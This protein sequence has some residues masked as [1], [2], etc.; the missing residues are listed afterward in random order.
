LTPTRRTARLRPQNRLDAPRRETSGPAR[1]FARARRGFTAALI[2]VGL[3]E[4]RADAAASADAPTLFPPVIVTTNGTGQD[5]FLMP[6][7]TAVLMEDALRDR[8]ARTLP[9]AFHEVPGIMVQKTGTAQGSPYLRGFTGFRTLLLVDG[10]RLNNSVFREGPNQYWGTVDPL[11]LERLEVVKGPGSVIHG[12]DAVGGTVNAITTPADISAAA[13]TWH[14]RALHRFATADESHVGRLEVAGRTAGNFS[15]RLGVSLKRFEDLRSGGGVQPHTGY[16][17]QGADLKAE[18]RTGPD[19][20]LSLLAQDFRQLDAWRTHTTVHGGT[21]AGTRPGSDLRRSLDQRRQLQALQYH[22]IRPAGTIDRWHV[23]LSRQRQE[24]DQLRIRSDRRREDSGFDVETLGIFAQAQIPTNRGRWVYGGELYRDRVVSR[25]L[26]Y[27]ADGTFQQR[28][29]QGPVAGRATYDLGGAYLEKRLRAAGGAQ[30]VAGGRFNHAAA[31]AREVR[32]PISGR[33]TAVRDHWNSVVGALRAVVPLGEEKR[34]NL[35]AGIGQAFRAPNLSDLTRFDIAEGG[36]IETPAP[37]LRPELS[38]TLEAGWRAREQRWSVELAFFRTN[39]RDQIIR[40]P[41]GARIDGLAEV[42]KRN[43]GTG[44]CHGVEAAGSVSPL[45]AWDVW[46]RGTWM[47]GELDYYPSAE[48]RGTVRGPMSRVMPPTAHAGVRWRTDGGRSWLEFVATAA[49]RQDRLAP[50]DLVDRE[51]IPPGGTPGY[52]VL[53]LRGGT[54]LGA[55][56]L[57]TA[58]LENI[59]DAD[60]R[61]HGSGVNEPGRNLVVTTEYR[62]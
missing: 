59:T 33:A 25:S 21:W 56:L 10:I 12:S 45:P 28:E 32:D 57:I 35:F 17:E 26:R 22:A 36:Q 48:A 20:R 2:A 37:G 27:L 55:R 29:I 43:S 61:I 6:Y 4:P 24:E 44:F 16:G 54:R 23:S 5:A 42:T 60:Y 53:G 52:R 19:A 11:G 1:Q 15:A 18:W 14:G 47:Q 7:A 13:G 30:L 40:T 34:Q 8:Q 39:L 51:R 9:S 41:T 50:G 3:I 31:E 46:I 38:T 58:A 49:A 62:F